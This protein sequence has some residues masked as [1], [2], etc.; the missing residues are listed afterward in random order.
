MHSTH[1][2]YGYMASDI[3][4]AN[5]HSERE[6]E[7]T[8]APSHRQDCTY[9][10]LCYTSCGA[11]AGMRNLVTVIRTYQAESWTGPATLE[12]SSQDKN[13]PS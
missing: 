6:R 1:L 4:M 13:L 2:I 11:L 12:C 7:E 5:D 3:I 8:Y 10:D 9:H